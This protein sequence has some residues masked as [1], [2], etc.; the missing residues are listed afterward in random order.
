MKHQNVLTF[1]VLILAIVFCVN[2]TYVSYHF[3]KSIDQVVDSLERISSD[4]SYYTTQTY[5]PFQM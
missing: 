5:P 3:V 4:V 1:V 2:I